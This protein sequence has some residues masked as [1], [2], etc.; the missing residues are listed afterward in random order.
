MIVIF[1]TLDGLRC[2]GNIPYKNPP[3]QVIRRSCKV[4]FPVT[5]LSN[6]PEESQVKYRT[7]Q[8]ELWKRNREAVPD[9]VYKE[10]E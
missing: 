7:Y 2:E 4:F 1:E 5:T 8:L 3:P 6:I 9:L 10:I